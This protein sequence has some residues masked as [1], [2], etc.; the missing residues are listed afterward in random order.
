MARV[1]VTL[2]P[3]TTWRGIWGPLVTDPVRGDRL[4]HVANPRRG[5]RERSIAAIRAVKM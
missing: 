1:R 3:S 2:W 4:G 5:G